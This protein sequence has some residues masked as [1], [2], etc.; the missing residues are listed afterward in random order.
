M[1]IDAHN[2]PDWYG[3]TLDKFIED[4][5]RVGI[6][7]TWLLSC[8]TP[9]DEYDPWE[10]SVYPS[11]FG[12][13]RSAIP[14]EC[15]IPY[16]QNC[17]NRFVLGFAPDPRRPD[18]INRLRSAINT[19]GVKI[20]GEVM[21]VS[22]MTDTIVHSIEAEDTAA[23]LLRFESGALGTVC[24][25]TSVCS[26]Q[27]RRLEISGEQGTIVLEEDRIVYSDV[28]GIELLDTMC[29]SYGVSDPLAIS[30][31]GHTRQYKN[32]FAALQGKE[33]L[34]YTASDAAN[35]VRLICAIYKANT[36]GKTQF[37]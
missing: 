32:I 30:T 37:V 29:T 6:D 5:D 3:K 11:I 22:A 36:C 31:D 2:H 34:I 1:I 21:M 28:A 14:F 25:T 7:K 9:E 16:V 17:P 15:S 27:P 8:E 4:M 23:A 19:Y 20:C 33:P 13:N 12:N 26:G 10:L 24:A 35:T 18:A